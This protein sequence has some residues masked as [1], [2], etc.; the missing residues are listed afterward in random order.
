MALTEKNNEAIALQVFVL[1]KYF[2]RECLQDCLGELYRANIK[3]K[4]YKL[5]YELNKDT[6]IRVRTAVGDSETREIS[7]G[8][9]QGSMEGSLVSSLSISQGV[10]DFFGTRE[11]EISYTSLGI[12]TGNDRLEAL[13]ETKLLDFHTLKSKIIIVGKAILHYFC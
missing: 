13:A 3:G 10:T 2:D 1:K 4:L 12:P 5:L 11:C 8:V 9:A 7:E 6:R